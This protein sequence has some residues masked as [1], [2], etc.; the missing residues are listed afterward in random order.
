MEHKRPAMRLLREHS[1]TGAEHPQVARGCTLSSCRL[2][3]GHDGCGGHSERRCSSTA[4]VHAEI[5]PR[6]ILAR[7]EANKFCDCHDGRLP[8]PPKH[9][10]ANRSRG[11][12]SRAGGSHS[13]GN[14]TATDKDT[15]RCEANE[16]YRVVFAGR[17]RC[18]RAKRAAHH[19][20]R[21]PYEGRVW[22]GMLNRRS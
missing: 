10:Y 12:S 17:E 6:P 1:G 19:E 7:C 14:L 9:Q 16:E 18:Q 5:V 15:L 11:N 21:P 4:A 20:I 3:K 13:I 8:H 22:T 2:A